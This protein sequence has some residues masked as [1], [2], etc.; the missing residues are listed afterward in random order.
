MFAPASSGRVVQRTAF[1]DYAAAAALRAATI[2]SAVRPLIS[3]IWSNLN[4]KLPTPA[5][6]ER[7]STIR[8]GIPVFGI[9]TFTPPQH[10]V[11]DLRFRHLH[12]HHVPAFPA[13]ARI[14]AEDLAAAPRHQ[15]VHLG[16]RLR[17][18]HDLHLV[19]GLEQHRLALRQ[20]FGNAEAASGVERHVGGIDGMI[21]AVDQLY[22]DVDHREA[23]RP[24]L[25]PIEDA[26]LHGWNIIAR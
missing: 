7:T 3:A 15:G 21:G 12:L 24:A 26:L 14:E 1:L 17:R 19:N 5:V 10:Q 23:E 25:E 16:G 9:G 2:W 18:Q 11:A 20:P 8:R 13:F 22:R 4:V 6:A